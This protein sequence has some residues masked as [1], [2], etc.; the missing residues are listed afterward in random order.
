MLVN[1][2]IAANEARQRELT[3]LVG[4]IKE[5]LGSNG[6]GAAG[7]DEV[8]GG[9]ERGQIQTMVVDR[10]Y[11]PA[12]LALP[13]LRLGRVSPRW[14]RCPLCGGAPVPIA[15]AVGEL[16]RLAILQSSRVEVAEDIPALDEMGGVAAL[17]R[18][19]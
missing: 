5:G 14:T 10:N 3:Q 13:G 16:V 4:R 1:A 9:L 7:F 8:L 17:L 18:F 6:H 15:D 12:G 2:R 11:R 19:A